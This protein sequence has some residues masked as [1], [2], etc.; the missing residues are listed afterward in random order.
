MHL[1][2]FGAGRFVAERRTFDEMLDVVDTVPRQRMGAGIGVLVAGADQLL[3][4]QDIEELL[5]PARRLLRCVQEF[6][7]CLVGFAFLRA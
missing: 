2:E 3:I 1:V 4:A 5:Q 7:R 6:Q